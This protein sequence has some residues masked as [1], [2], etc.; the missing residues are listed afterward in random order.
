M[1]F[2]G[3]YIVSYNNGCFD[4][5]TTFSQSVALNALFNFLQ[6]QPEKFGA[7]VIDDKRLH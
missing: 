2:G 7:C 1:S 4:V 5:H 6:G 3:Y